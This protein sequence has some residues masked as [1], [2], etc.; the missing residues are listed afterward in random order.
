MRNLLY[1][2]LAGA[3]IV[4]LMMISFAA[5]GGSTHSPATIIVQTPVPAPAPI[6]VQTPVPQPVQ[7]VEYAP[8]QQVYSASM[9][10]PPVFIERESHQTRNVI[11]AAGIGFVVGAI[12]NRAHHRPTYGQYGWGGGQPRGRAI[13]RRPMVPVYGQPNRGRRR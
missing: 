1:A 6:I 11:A 13:G 9:A 12:A 3:L 2:A 8:P 5:G 4:V 7:Q 10:Q